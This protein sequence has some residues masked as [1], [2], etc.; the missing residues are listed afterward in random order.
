MLTGKRVK[1]SQ[2]IHEQRCVVRVEV[3]AII[4]DEDPSEP[5]FEPAA[6]KWMDRLQQLADE[7]NVAELAK[8]GQ[9]YVRQSA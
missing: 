7:G 4:P 1:V 3:E 6:V 8:A 2:W 9:I 5:C